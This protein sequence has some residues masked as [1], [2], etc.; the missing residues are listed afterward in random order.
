MAVF[1]HAFGYTS[2]EILPL[3]SPFLVSYAPEY[4]A[5]VV[6]VAADHTLKQVD[7]FLVHASEAVFVDYEEA[8]AVACVKHCR[9]HRVVARTVCVA[10]QF[11]QLHE[12]P[13][14]KTVRYG[15]TYS[16]MVLMATDSLDPIRDI[17]QIHSPL[18]RPSDISQTD[19]SAYTINTFFC[20][21]Q[22]TYKSI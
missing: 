5:R 7:M 9:S 2:S 4:H 8:E 12:S 22:F 1:A 21:I 17:I 13:L 6:A 14:L 19:H 16:G 15:R 11:L 20:V 10:S 3:D 18:C